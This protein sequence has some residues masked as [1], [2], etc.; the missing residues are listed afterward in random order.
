MEQ[1]LEGYGP[2]C[3]LSFVVLGNEDSLLLA[4][5]YALSHKESIPEPLYTILPDQYKLSQH[6]VTMVPRDNLQRACS[7]FIVSFEGELEPS[8]KMIE[9]CHSILN[10]RN[11]PEEGDPLGLGLNQEEK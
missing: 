6:S 1:S 9:R 4:V 2:C 8:R 7:E 5:S 11:H 10:K 3:V